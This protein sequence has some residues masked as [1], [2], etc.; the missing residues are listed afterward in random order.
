ML[1][2]SV[3]IQHSRAARERVIG[4]VP[5]FRRLGRLDY[6]VFTGHLRLGRG[7]VGS[8]AASASAQ[9]RSSAKRAAEKNLRVLK[10]IQCIPDFRFSDRWLQPV[11]VAARL[12][13]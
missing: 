8:Q 7:A 4:S 2:F 6:G 1:P 12:F 3:L 5:G 11:G 10:F 9:A 13:A